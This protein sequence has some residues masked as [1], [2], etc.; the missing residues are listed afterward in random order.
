MAP[1]RMAARAQP[2]N[3]LAELRS[4]RA[5]S[6]H[7]I[8]LLRPP[9]LYA[10]SYA[11]TGVIDPATAWPCGLLR[12]LRGHLRQ[13]AHPVSRPGSSQIDGSSA[14]RPDTLLYKCTSGFHSVLSACARP[15]AAEQLATS[16]AA[17]CAQ[18]PP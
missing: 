12:A 8:Q 9:T 17:Q 10:Q 16:I 6:V 3:S 2:Q 11:S 7:N 15:A 18:Q 14:R 4:T 1:N 13:C 5:Q